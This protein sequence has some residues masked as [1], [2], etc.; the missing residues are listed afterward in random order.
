MRL[1]ELKAAN[2][3]ESIDLADAFLSRP[4]LEGQYDFLSSKGKHDLA[5]MFWVLK[6]FHPLWSKLL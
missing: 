1:E 3:R 5:R 6:T 2:A 4:F